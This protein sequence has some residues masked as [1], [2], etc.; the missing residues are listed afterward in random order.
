MKYVFYALKM[1]HYVMCLTPSENNTMN[2]LKE[3]NAVLKR[4]LSFS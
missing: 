4:E 1:S 3:F 2:W